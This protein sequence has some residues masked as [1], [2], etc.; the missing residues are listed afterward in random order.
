MGDVQH[1]DGQMIVSGRCGEGRL[2]VGDAFNIKFRFVPRKYPEEMGNTAQVEAA[3][4]INLR[5]VRI[6]MYG[7][8]RPHI[9]P[10]DTGVLCL[11]GRVEIEHGWDLGFEC[12]HENKKSCPGEEWC[13]DCGETLWRD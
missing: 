10:V 12:T 3:W 8:D 2:S 7:K 13:E 1:K 11:E 5:I 4:P 9:D 6:E